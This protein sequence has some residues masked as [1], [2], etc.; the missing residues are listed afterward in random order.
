MIWW[1]ML[2]GAALVSVVVA[3]VFVRFMWGLWN[4]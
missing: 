1:G 4:R 2:I 3:V